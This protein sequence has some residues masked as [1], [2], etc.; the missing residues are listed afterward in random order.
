M[1]KF[2]FFILILSVFILTVS[3]LPS[4]RAEVGMGTVPTTVLLSPVKTREPIVIV[5]PERYNGQC[6]RDEPA[7]EK[8]IAELKKQY[9]KIGRFIPSVSREKGGWCFSYTIRLK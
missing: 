4:S 2:N 3:F 7:M 6:F 8:R 5:N 1:N 9:E